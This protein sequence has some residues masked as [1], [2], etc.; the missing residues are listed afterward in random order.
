VERNLLK[1]NKKSSTVFE[2]KKIKAEKINL[3]KEIEKLEKENNFREI[4]DKTVC[5]KMGN[6]KKSHNKTGCTKLNS[7]KRRAF[8]FDYL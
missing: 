4:R 3:N 6:A 8:L 5:P 1:I 7:Q 2:R